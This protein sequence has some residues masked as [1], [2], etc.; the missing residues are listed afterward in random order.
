MSLTQEFGEYTDAGARGFWLPTYEETRALGEIHRADKERD[1]LTLVWTASSGL[2]DY[3]SGNVLME[4]GE[5]KGGAANDMALAI[6]KAMGLGQK[7][8]PT[9]VLCDPHHYLNDEKFGPFIRA[10]RQVAAQKKQ[11]IVCLTPQPQIPLDL[12]HTYLPLELSLPDREELAGIAR[13]IKGLPK[14]V[15]GIAEAALAMTGF[16]AEILMRRALIRH[17]SVAERIAQDVW[18]AKA[19]IMSAKGIH[20]VRPTLK[21]DAVGGAYHVKQWF[22]QNRWA[23]SPEGRMRGLDPKGV[24]FVGP[25]GTGKTLIAQCIAAELGWNF[26]AMNVSE[27]FDPYQ[28]VTEINV[29]EALQTLR[30]YAPVFAFFDEARHQFRGHESSG[31]TDSGT[32]AR[33]IGEVLKFLNDRTESVFSG[34]ATNEPWDMPS[35]MLRSGR[36]NAVLNIGNPRQDASEEILFIH[37]DRYFPDGHKIERKAAR[38]LIKKMVER[39]FSGSDIAETVIDVARYVGSG[40]PTIEALTKA[41]GLRKSYAETMPEQVN[42]IEEWARAHAICEP[43]GDNA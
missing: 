39:R 4:A 2:T 13:K 21:F 6:D 9:L 12:R 1:R 37:L 22:E 27:F 19:K 10:V 3:A 29:R 43:V 41:A 28:G 11:T 42:K 33:M 18:N 36:I 23:F 15:E 5:S 25:P 17:G 38:E 7:A 32:T 16:E 8:H 31:M 30:V 34:F 20:V 40:T 14:Q 35:H 26:V 24:L